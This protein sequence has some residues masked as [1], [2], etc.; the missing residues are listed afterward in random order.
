[1]TKDEVLRL[2]R[3]RPFQPFRIITVVDEAIDVW[4][5]R[6]MLVAGN[7]LTI[8]QPD[9]KEPPPAASDGTWLGFEDIARVEPLTAAVK[10]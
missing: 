8:G 10:T 3:Q 6:L 9:P 2:W 1:M 4:H 5:P 7:M